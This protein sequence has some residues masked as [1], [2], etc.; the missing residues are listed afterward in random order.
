MRIFALFLI[1]CGAGFAET[2][3]VAPPLDCQSCDA[4]HAQLKK[5]KQATLIAPA[6][7]S[8][9]A[10]STGTPPDDEQKEDQDN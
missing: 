6:P 10:Q 1:M 4:R 3:P 9:E 5:L 8:G 2:K 7:K